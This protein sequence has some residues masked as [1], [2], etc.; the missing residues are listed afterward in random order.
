MLPLILSTF[1]II[2][3]AEL[4][5]KTALASLVLATRYPARQVV[6]GAWLAF[7]VQTLVAVAAGSLFQLLRLSRCDSPLAQAS[8]CSRGSRCDGKKRKS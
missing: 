7:L 8:S 5:D 4:P 1:G 6:L 2:F 3:L